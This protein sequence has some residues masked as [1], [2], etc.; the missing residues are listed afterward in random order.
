[1]SERIQKLISAA[2]IASRRAAEKMIEDGRV[3]VNGCTASL[4]M[5]A[6]P[7]ND[8]ITVDGAT[9]SF[10]K[11]HWYIMLNKPRGFVTTMH[12]E[13]GRKTVAELVADVGSRVYPVGRLDM[14]S[15][16]LLIMTDDG[17]AANRLMHPSH[18]IKKTYLTWVVGAN[19]HQAVELMSGKMN[20]DGH[21][22]GPSE[23]EIR[24]ETDKNALLSVTISEGRNRQIR[25]MCALAGLR[26]ARLMRVKEGEIC[27]GDLQTGHWRFLTEDEISFL[28]K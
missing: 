9:L 10:P 7:E 3:Q 27:L 20:I 23:V 18:N 17:A 11:E 26:V 2:G 12:D 28:T 14:D 1:M 25:K 15:E 24:S 8:S 4:G 13:Q 19:F 16:G 21:M 5:S 22:V 6:D